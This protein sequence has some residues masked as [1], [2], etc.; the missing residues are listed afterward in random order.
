MAVS[1]ERVCPRKPLRNIFTA[2][3][4]GTLVNLAAPHHQSAIAQQPVA[5]QWAMT[6]TPVS[7]EASSA[8]QTIE[9]VINT[10]REI[11]ADQAFRRVR[12]Q[13]PKV[14][15]ALPLEGGNRLQLSALATGVTQ[16]DLMGDDDSVHTIEIMVLGDVREL[17]AII[18]KEY[19]SANIGITPIQGGCII[20]GYVSNDEHVEQMDQIAKQYF[21]TVINKIAV[22]GVHTIQL[23]TQIMEVSRT[24]L[25]ALGID[26][27]FANGD[28]I[29]QSTVSGLVTSVDGAFSG[30]GNQTFSVGVVE[31]GS[32]FFTAIRALRQNS[33]VKVLASPTLTAVDGRPASFNAGGEIP[34]VVPAGL[35]QVGVQYREF[36]TRL[37]YVAK[38][39]GNGRIWLEVRPY[40]SEIDPSRSVSIQGVSV[41][42]LRSRFLETGVEMG[43]GQTLAL[44]GLL[45]VKSETIN[46]GVPWLSD[47]PYLGAF[48]RST[49]EEQNEIELLITVTPNFAGPMDPHEVPL[50]APGTMTQSPSDRELYW[51][52]YMETPLSGLDDAN[53]NPG[54]IQSV[55]GGYPTDAGYPGMEPSYGIAVPAQQPPLPVPNPAAMSVG[56]N[57]PRLVQ[58][59]SGPQQPGYTQPN[60]QQNYPMNSGDPNRSTNTAAGGNSIL[61]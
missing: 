56:P 13:N 43:A 40:V 38:V 28:D 22:T 49:R 5:S 50:Q 60:Y 37:D 45:Q 54:L 32:S 7:V 44:A 41:P 25:R 57:A 27:A 46:I 55:P 52:G 42:G 6:N 15:G 36:G 61:R 26:Y 31:N 17:E 51:R 1:K 53:C 3:L 47:M 8:R 29:I 20:S 39:R 48:F 12:I 11:T 33:L 16:V 34:I 9:M 19:P 10:S 21:P 18:R 2:A 58:Q 35:G 59:A 4:I 14:V 23:E 30:A 24:K